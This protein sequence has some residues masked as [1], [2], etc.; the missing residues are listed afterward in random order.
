MSDQKEQQ[1]GSKEPEKATIS[2]WHGDAMDST[3]KLPMHKD[4]RTEDDKRRE[5]EK[6]KRKMH[7]LLWWFVIGLIVLLALVFLLG[8]LPRHKRNEETKKQAEAQKNA[9][10]VV[11]V[12]QVKNAPPAGDLTVPGTTTP[13]T[14]ANVYARANGY[15]K[16]RYVDIGDRVHQG[17]LLAVIDAPDLDQQVDQARA[18]VRQAESQ[19][20]Q[21]QAQL[22]LTRVTWDRWKVLV[23]KGV[24]SRQDGDQRQTDY[25]AA[26]SNVAAAQRNVQ[27]FQANLGRQLALQQFER[28]TS[29]FDGI[30]TA[31][32]VDVGSL[33]SAQ[34]SGGGDTTSA[35][36][37]MGSPTQAGSTNTSGTTGSA[38]T[39]ASPNTG[40]AQGGAL[41]SVAQ[42]NRLRILVSVPEGYS[43][44]VKVGQQASLRL[45]SF[46]GQTFYGRVTRT[47]GSIDQNSR[48]LLTEV[49]VD[50]RDGRLLTG[51]Y[52]IVSFVNMHGDPGITVPGD[53]I[54]VRADKNQVAVV[55]DDTIHMQPVEIGRDFGPSVEIVSGLK[56]GD[57]IATTVSDEVKEGVKIKTRQGKTPGE[58]TNATSGQKQDQKPG[59]AAQY[60][61]QEIV[62][63]GEGG[64]QQQQ[65]SGGN[66]GGGQQGNGGKQ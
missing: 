16:R 20:A 50:N 48:T 37:N 18:S 2:Q 3:S 12:L 62:G 47:S 56:T 53:A 26:L 28:V 61:N 14:Q 38:S 59:V 25:N 27:S 17:Q 54:V 44:A 1:G 11:E 39:A 29:P 19:L 32:N 13:L 40:G 22:D 8:F 45:Q 21:Q 36:E 7:R 49:Q 63:S 15:L 66:K 43:T 23:A 31:R 58:N 52:V 65:K 64:G 42:V 33:I 34:G 24:F 4:T 55:R 9:V 35:P 51:M 6:H 60:G 57:V 5:E 46:P 41:F 30:I 10:P